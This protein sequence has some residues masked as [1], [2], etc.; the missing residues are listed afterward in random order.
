MSGHVH[1]VKLAG[2]NS[3]NIHLVGLF[4]LY[5]ELAEYDYSFFKHKLYLSEDT[6][7]HLATQAFANIDK[8]VVAKV[9]TR[10][11]GF[12]AVAAGD[13]NSISELFVVEEYRRQGIAREMV[14]QLR[15]IVPGKLKV[16]SILGNKDSL[17]FYESMGFVA[18]T[19]GMTEV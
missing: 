17:A 6:R 7:A 13:P 11:V 16:N 12:V 5:C 19:I 2:V 14:K 3:Q 4:P 10:F 9:G 8:L 15:E 1:Y 18:I